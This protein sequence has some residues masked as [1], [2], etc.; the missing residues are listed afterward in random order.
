MPVVGEWPGPS[1]HLETKQ[2][3]DGLSPD[4]EA[5]ST[6]RLVRISPSKAR[7]THVHPYSEEVIYI[8]RGEGWLWESG[9]VTGVTRG[10][11]IYI[12]QGVEHVTFA[13]RES[14]LSLVCFFPHPDLGA[15]LEERSERLSPNQI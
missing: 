12:P 4:L 5:A 3:A 13:R 15:N 11:V 8:E 1:T 6:V 9:E 7:R 10:D 2:S 14:S